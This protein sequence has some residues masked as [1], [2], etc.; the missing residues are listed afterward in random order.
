MGATGPRSYV[1]AYAALFFL[2]D[3]ESWQQ[4]LHDAMPEI[5]KKITS[6]Y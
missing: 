1:A 2:W 6:S 4:G 3:K 5:I